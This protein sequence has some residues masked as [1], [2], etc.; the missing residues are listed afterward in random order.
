VPITLETMTAAATGPARLRVVLTDDHRDFAERALPWLVG[1]PVRTNV[2]ATMLA[3]V[4]D[5]GV[6]APG[7]TWVLVE[8]GGRVVGAG[9]HTPPHPVYLPPMPDGAAAAVAGAFLD[10]GREVA[11]V[12]GGPASTAEFAD[13]W[14]AATGARARLGRAEGVHVLG[15][16]I[17]PTVIAGRPR[18]ATAT[19][20]EESQ[21]WLV[22]FHAE[23]SPL[24]PA[25]QHVAEVVAHR[26]RLGLLMLWDDGTHPVSLAGWHL[27]VAGVG[28]V[29]PV[30][31]PPQHRRHGYAAG[32][33][34]AASQAVLAAGAEQVMLFTDLANPTSNGVY[35]R[36]GYQ[37][38]GDASE[39]LFTPA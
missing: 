6:L 38:V 20:A 16:L 24:E 26:I 33:T 12:N 30:Y 7:S 32:V 27:P 37:R 11:G 25:Q 29:G 14:C 10:A 28:R 39:W 5:G 13:A 17:P 22:A 4:R 31:T 36:L 35:A 18:P 9:M 34:A 2:V 21:R 3:T 15:T 19:D 1:D 23:S 8:R